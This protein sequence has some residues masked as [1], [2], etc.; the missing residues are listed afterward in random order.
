MPFMEEIRDEE[1]Y[2]IMRELPH[3]MSKRFLSG[4]GESSTKD[5][6]VDEETDL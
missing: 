1:T 3:I 4:A 6:N 2:F 5:K